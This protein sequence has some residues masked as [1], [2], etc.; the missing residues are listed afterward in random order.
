[1][2]SKPSAQPVSLAAA[3]SQPAALSYLAV[4]RASPFERIA[5]IKRG[6]S[7][8]EAKRMFAHL[9]LGQGAALKALNLSPATVNKKAKRDETLSPEESERVIGIAKLVGQL[10]AMVEES[11]NAEGFDATAWIARW[12][13]EPLP[14]LGG[15]R[16]VELMDTMEGQALVAETLAQIQSGA[17]A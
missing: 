13:M 6:I 12:L 2:S 3:Q 15:A 9:N 5:M 10:E 16:P 17:Y 4:Y 1:M 11:G 8:T 7:A 14:A